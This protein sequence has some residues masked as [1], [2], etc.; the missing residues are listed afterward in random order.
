MS[1]YVFFLQFEKKLKFI[2]VKY[3]MKHLSVE[4]FLFC[5]YI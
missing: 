1:V 5:K 4:D 2:L 3:N